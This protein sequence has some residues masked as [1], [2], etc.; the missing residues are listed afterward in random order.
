MQELSLTRIP[1]GYVASLTT[2]LIVALVAPSGLTAQPL[3]GETLPFRKGQWAAQF[4]FFGDAGIGALRFRSPSSA[5]VVNG[6]L[7]AG[8]DHSTDR[9][10]TRASASVRAGLRSYRTVVPRIARYHG[11]GIIADYSHYE[12]EYESDQTEAIS[13]AGGGGLYGELG[14]EY[15]ITR[16][17]SLG[18]NTSASA[19][20]RGRKEG[21]ELYN[22]SDF[23]WAVAAGGLRVLATLYF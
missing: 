13:R 14:A 17:L 4:W 11:G 2:F 21:R 22:Y 8:G 19:M 12:S 3:P 18:A 10:T 6:S 20:V 5:W 23:G 9:R 1:R 15:L 7:Q 16:H